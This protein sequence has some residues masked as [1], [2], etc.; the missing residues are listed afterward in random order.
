[1]ETATSVSPSVELI[2]NETKCRPV[3]REFGDV[4]NGGAHQRSGMVNISVLF[5]RINYLYIHVL[6]KNV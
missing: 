1:V 5:V 3:D 4:N 6:C 2:N